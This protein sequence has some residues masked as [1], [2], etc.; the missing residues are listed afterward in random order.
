MKRKTSDQEE[1]EMR[2]IGLSIVAAVGI[3]SAGTTVAASLPADGVSIARLGQQ[4]DAVN[5]VKAKKP[6]TKTTG[7]TTPRPRQPSES[8]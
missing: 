4:I 1:D 7:T 5:G 6:K 3:L 8:Y 2:A